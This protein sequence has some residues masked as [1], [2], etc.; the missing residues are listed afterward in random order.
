MKEK[1]LPQFLKLEDTEMK[2]LL[3]EKGEN[4]NQEK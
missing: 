1:S 2:A 3:L 4:E